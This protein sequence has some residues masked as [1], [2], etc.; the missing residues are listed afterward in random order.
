MQWQEVQKSNMHK[1]YLVILLLH[2]FKLRKKIWRKGITV[3]VILLNLSKNCQFVTSRYLTS[4]KVAF[5]PYCERTFYILLTKRYALSAGKNIRF[6]ECMIS[7]H[8]HH[9]FCLCHLKLRSFCCYYSFI[10]SVFFDLLS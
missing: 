2:N 1:R 5:Y 6:E 8:H 10:L 9:I 7:N 3:K 4:I